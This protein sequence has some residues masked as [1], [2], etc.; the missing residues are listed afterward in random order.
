[1]VSHTDFF[2]SV[3]YVTAAIT[4]NCKEFD[5]SYPSSPEEQRKIA[6]VFRSKSGVNFDKCA[7]AIDG[8]LIWISKPSEKDAKKTKIGKK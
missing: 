5:I 4:N 1:M 3:W 7:G 8:I 6:E 2:D